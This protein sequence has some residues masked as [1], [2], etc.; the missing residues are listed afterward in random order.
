MLPLLER[1][2]LRKRRTSAVYCVLRFPDSAESRW[3]D[4]PPNPGQRLRSHGGD[5]YWGQVWVVDEVLQSGRDMY[6]VFCVGRDDYR[7]KLRHGSHGEPGLATDLLEVVRRT[8]E[9][10]SEL[11]RRRKMRHYQP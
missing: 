6:T 8:A 3:F 9:T 10:A 1:L 4:K 7:D 11:R 2:S 5:L